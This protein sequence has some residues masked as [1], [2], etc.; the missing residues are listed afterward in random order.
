MNEGMNK[1]QKTCKFDRK[2][3]KKG[4]NVWKEGRKERKKKARKEGIFETKKGREERRMK[5]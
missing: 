1:M 2:K 3:K 4:R 5:E